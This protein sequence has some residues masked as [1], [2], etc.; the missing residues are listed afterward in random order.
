MDKM[1]NKILD[2]SYG[3]KLEC[4]FIIIAI[5]CARE[6][7]ALLLLVLFW[8]FSRNIFMDFEQANI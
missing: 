1:S 4:A 7:Y 2:L 8:S 5:M 3:Y 6:K